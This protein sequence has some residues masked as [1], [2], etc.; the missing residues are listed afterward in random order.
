[1]GNIDSLFLRSLNSKPKGRPS[2]ASVPSSPAKVAF[3]YYV[4]IR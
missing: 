4:H 1:M 2:D 3:H